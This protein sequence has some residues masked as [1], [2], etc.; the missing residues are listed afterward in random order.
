MLCFVNQWSNGSRPSRSVDACRWRGGRWRDRRTS[1]PTSIQSMHGNASWTVFFCKSLQ[2]LNP[3]DVYPSWVQGHIDIPLYLT[4]Y[5]FSVSSPSVWR[6]WPGP[7]G[8][9][10]NM[11]RKMIETAVASSYYVLL[12][13]L[14]GTLDTTRLF[15]SKALKNVAIMWARSVRK[16]QTCYW[17][18]EVTI[19]GNITVYGLRSKRPNQK[20]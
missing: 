13:G 1:R 17:Q 14:L 16:R 3:Q 19:A 2:E 11:I 10:G 7:M 15:G 18:I 4:R 5:T 12:V 20:K 9:P 6:C 8:P